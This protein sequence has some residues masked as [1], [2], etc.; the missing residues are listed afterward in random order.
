MEGAAFSAFRAAAAEGRLL[1][2]VCVRCARAHWYPRAFCPL[3]GGPDI[4]WQ[5]A[6]GA[7]TVYSVSVVRRTETPYALVLVTLDEGPTVLSNMVECD[8]DAV[9]IG[10]RVRALVTAGDGVIPLILFTP[11][12]QANP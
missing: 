3:C 11:E 10:D 6:T 5:A 12:R 4:E 2:P 7:G 9:R 8:L 1:L